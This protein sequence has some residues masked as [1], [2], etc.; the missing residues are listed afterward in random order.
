MDII[1]CRSS[2]Q[3]LQKLKSKCAEEHRNLTL[4]LD[5]RTRW[6]STYHMLQ[7]AILLQEA[8][9]QVCS[10]DRD[11]MA[12]VLTE[13]DWEFAQSLCNLLAPFANLTT[14]LSTDRSYASIPI[15]ISGFNKLIDTLEQYRRSLNN[16]RK[17]SDICKAVLKA[18]FKLQEYYARTDLTPIYAVGTALDPRR[19]FG[20][21]RH[22]QWEDRYQQQAQDFVRDVWREEYEVNIPT[23][24]L[25]SPGPY[26]SCED[27]DE[28]FTDLEKQQE[29]LG[30]ELEQYIEDRG[31]VNLVNPYDVFPFWRMHHDRWPT[32]TQ[33][34][35]AYLA[36][37]AT[38]TSSERAFSQA[39][40]VL[41]HTRNRLNAGTIKTLLELENW[42]KHLN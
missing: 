23:Q 22:Q 12:H 27:D 13:R 40:L 31:H 21:W 20:W 39:R 30:S 35:R 38:S 8:Y 14:K 29:P 33:M 6:S 16:Q 2:P 17:F 32:L 26:A 4:I 25:A 10:M 34:A 37:P 3:R 18:K 36:I 11:L 41:P 19:K 42:I 7:R 5:C 28:F 15:V 9:N 1:S 24:P